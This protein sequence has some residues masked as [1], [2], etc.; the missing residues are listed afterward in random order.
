MTRKYNTV[1]RSLACLF[2]LAAL[3]VAG[4][5]SAGKVASAVT[6]DNAPPEGYNRLYFS[7]GPY[8]ASFSSNGAS[9]NPCG[10]IFNP[11]S[12]LFSS[13]NRVGSREGERSREPCLSWH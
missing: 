8:G 3:C 4:C 9:F 7:T 11:N 5:R 6:Q 2:L 10:G 12:A 1:M 13:M